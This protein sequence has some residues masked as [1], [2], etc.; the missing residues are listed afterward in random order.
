M[1]YM[2]LRENQ[3]KRLVENFADEQEIFNCFQKSHFEFKYSTNKFYGNRKANEILYSHFFGLIFHLCL[4]VSYLTEVEF[5][6]LVF[7]GV[8]YVYCIIGYV[9]R[10]ELGRVLLFLFQGALL[11]D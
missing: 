9:I 6:F 2:E 7:L 3:Q 8:L 11:V 1:D 10:L 4:H 5:P